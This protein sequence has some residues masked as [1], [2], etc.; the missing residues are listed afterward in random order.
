VPC[1]NTTVLAAH[2]YNLCP[3]AETR[4]LGVIAPSGVPL[5]RYRCRAERATNA[6]EVSREARERLIPQAAGV[7]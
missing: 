3:T 2:N 4:I 5:D 7:P 6:H 1:R